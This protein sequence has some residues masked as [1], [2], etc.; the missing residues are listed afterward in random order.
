MILKK[1]RRLKVQI[2]NNLFVF[3]EMNIPTSVYLRIMILNLVFSVII[4]HNF[5]MFEL[6]LNANGRN[7]FAL[8]YSNFSKELV[9]FNNISFYR[10]E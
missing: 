6:K 4:A 9:E 1:F 8:K 10:K 5:S 2:I 7:Y 3:F